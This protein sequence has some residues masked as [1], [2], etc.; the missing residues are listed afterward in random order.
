MG[1]PDCAEAYVRSCEQAGLLEA[2]AD[3]NSPPQQ[4]TEVTQ[5][6]EQQALH[7]GMDCLPG[8]ESSMEAQDA[9]IGQAE[10]WPQ[11]EL[12]DL[13][14]HQTC[15]MSS[16]RLTNESTGTGGQSAAELVREITTAYTNHL[17][18]LISR[19]C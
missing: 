2:R 14:S 8:A 13:L 7:Q 10:E 19:L 18:T 12:F 1:L 6:G 16:S 17:C 15:L 3:T 4:H 5:H 11:A 9:S